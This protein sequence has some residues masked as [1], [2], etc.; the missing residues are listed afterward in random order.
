MRISDFNA[1]KDEVGPPTMAAPGASVL[2]LKIPAE[3]PPEGRAQ[4]EIALLRARIEHL[5][6]VVETARGLMTANQEKLLRRLHEVP[7]DITALTARLGRFG[8]SGQA[9]EIPWYAS[10]ISAGGQT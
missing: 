6:L 8:E 4:V 1:P 10:Q 2:A 7:R 5:E 9:G 3:Y